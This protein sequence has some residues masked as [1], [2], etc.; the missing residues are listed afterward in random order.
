[1]NPTP[2][3]GLPFSTTSGFTLLFR[4]HTSTE[5]SPFTELISLTCSQC[6]LKNIILFSDNIFKIYDIELFTPLQ[7]KVAILKDL[8][9]LKDMMQLT[10]NVSQKC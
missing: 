1:M 10:K 6:L 4:K 7:L 3:Y 5:N 8:N 9:G 2:P